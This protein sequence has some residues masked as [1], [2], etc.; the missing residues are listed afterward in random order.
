M[1]TKTFPVLRGTTNRQNGAKS[2]NLLFTQQ[3]FTE[4]AC[5]L[6][7]KIKPDCLD[8]ARTCDARHK[9]GKPVRVNRSGSRSLEYRQ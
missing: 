6:R 9:S 5:D 3:V 7:S 4:R 2:G 1:A 8:F